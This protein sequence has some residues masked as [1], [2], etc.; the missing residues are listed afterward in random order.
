M[1]GMVS[2]R[3]TVRQT[4]SQMAARAVAAH[5]KEPECRYDPQQQKPF[6]IAELVEP[7]PGAEERAMY[8]ITNA[9]LHTPIHGGV[10]VG[11]VDRAKESRSADSLNK[12]PLNNRSR[13]E[14]TR[15]KQTPSRGT[16]LRLQAGRIGTI[17]ISPM[18]G[19]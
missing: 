12:S 5:A 18:C 3:V 8:P 1:V 19:T 9:G 15:A 13:T 7:V 11:V 6:L 17:G 16:R 4:G 14:R 2:S 10:P